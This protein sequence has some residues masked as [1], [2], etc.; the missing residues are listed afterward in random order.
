MIDERDLALADASPP[1]TI[2]TARW[3]EP[4]SARNVAAMFWL[5]STLAPLPRDPFGKTLPVFGNMFP[6]LRIYNDVHA[7]TVGRSLF[8][9][10]ISDTE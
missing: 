4:S 3:L 5:K 6:P 8:P 2:L 7:E 9:P 10:P 1:I